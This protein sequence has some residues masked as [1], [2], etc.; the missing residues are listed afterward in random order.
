MQVE[1][2]AENASPTCNSLAKE[3]SSAAPSP[4]PHSDPM[5]AVCLH[6]TASIRRHAGAPWLQL[7][8]AL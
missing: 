6:T 5:L 2:P 1:M 7:H 4:R 3:A 8:V